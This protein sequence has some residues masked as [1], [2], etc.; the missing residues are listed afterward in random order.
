[1]DLGGTAGGVQQHQGNASQTSTTGR[2]STPISSLVNNDSSY[3][4]RL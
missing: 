1:V 3:L 4:L 2:Y